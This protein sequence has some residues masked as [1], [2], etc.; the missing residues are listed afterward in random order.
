[1]I[2]AT[3]DG[4]FHADDVLG[5]VVL[6]RIF[7]D[8][9]FIRTRDPGKLASADIVF[10]VGGV[11]DT[12]RLRFDHHMLSASK[13]RNGIIYSALGLLWQEYGLQYCGMNKQVWKH[14]DQFLVES[15]DA[16]DNGQR[17]DTPNEYGVSRPT[18]DSLIRTFNPVAGEDFDTQFYKAV[19]FARTLLE[20]L[21]MAAVSEFD[22][23]DDIV[24]QY[25]KSAHEGFVVLDYYAPIHDIRN[26]PAQLKY[27]VCREK[28]D[29]WLVGAVQDSDLFNS[30]RRPF[31]ASWSGLS[32]DAF[33]AVT[34][35][36]GVQSC[37]R[38]LF[39]A[40]A[41]TK[42]AAIALAKKAL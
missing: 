31:P 30:L 10:D 35:V 14:I 6:Q 27:I 5:T 4:P 7:P 39:I 12:K 18:F 20:R 42:E 25:E 41:Y 38:N 32:G 11:Q 1:M 26:L 8:A 23:Y 37:H 36:E 16:D 21:K 19:E 40:V 2:I 13:R 15:I 22:M 28:D 24:T 9:T 34:G 33:V 29:R 17:I 3:H